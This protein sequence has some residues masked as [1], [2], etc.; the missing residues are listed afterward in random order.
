MVLISEASK[1][2]VLLKLTDPREDRIE[3]ANERKRAKYAE[4]VEECR[5]NGWPAR[6]EPIEVGCRGFC[7]PAPLQ[8]IQHA[9]HHRG[10]SVKGHQVGH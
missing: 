8:G 1:Q 9:G 3:E 4:L 2:I 5:S 10:Q 7:R 6:C